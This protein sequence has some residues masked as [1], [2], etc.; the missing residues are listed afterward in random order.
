MKVLSV[1][2]RLGELEERIITLRFDSGASISLIAESYLN[3]MRRPPKIHTG[4]KI[5]LAQLIDQSP[6]I[7][8]YVNMP[9]RI[10]AQ[11]G[12]MLVFSAELYVVPDMTVEVLL[13]EDFQLNHELSVLRDVERGTKIVVGQTGYSFDAT[14]TIGPL[15]RELTRDK[16]SMDGSIRVW[17]DTVILPETTTPIPV[18]GN[19]DLSKEW[20]FERNL[21][22]LPG[23]EFLTVPNALIGGTHAGLFLPVANPT[24]VP[25]IVRAGTLLGFAKD[26]QEHL[27]HARND[28]EQ[29]DM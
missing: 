6:R 24:K 23:D 26:P 7:K 20:Y 5:S 15:S 28:Q 22:P 4:L 27:N 18:V 12:T 14:S 16:A 1:E 25:R 11:D 19:L 3:R 9:V 13:G 29:M 2:G 21:I 8:G 10:P 17:E